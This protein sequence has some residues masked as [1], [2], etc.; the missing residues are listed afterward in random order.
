MG[1]EIKEF[2]SSELGYLIHTLSVECSY[3]E[4]KDANESDAISFMVRTDGDWDGEVVSDLYYYIGCSI[5][6]A[7]EFANYILS[8]CNEVES[9]MRNHYDETI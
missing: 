3:H 7:R 2:T 6:D 1:K 5:E 8:L 4:F 9:E